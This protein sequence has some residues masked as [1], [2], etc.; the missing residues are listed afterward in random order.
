MNLGSF[1]CWVRY[2]FVYRLCL[3]AKETEQGVTIKFRHRPFRAS[4]ASAVL[5]CFLQ[6]SH[7][8]GVKCCTVLY[9]AVRVCTVL[10]GAVQSCTV[11]YGAVRSNKVGYIPQNT[12]ARLNYNLAF[13]IR[14]SE[15]AQYF[16][17]FKKLKIYYEPSSRLS[18]YWLLISLLAKCALAL[19]KTLN[20]WACLIR[21]IFAISD[22]RYYLTVKFRQLML[23]RL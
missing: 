21:F 12:R 15:L 4:L 22:F 3:I 1:R 6:P 9:G 11:L 18:E 20:A 10:Y 23:I 2:S 16:F 14:R 5:S 19:L 13:G 17:L 8:K 7:N